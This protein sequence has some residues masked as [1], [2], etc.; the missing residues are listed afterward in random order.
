MGQ[1]TALDAAKDETL[2]SR[3]ESNTYFSAVLPVVYIDYTI[4]LSFN[5]H[6]KK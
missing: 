6:K 3:R 1:T 2:F 4:P 5:S